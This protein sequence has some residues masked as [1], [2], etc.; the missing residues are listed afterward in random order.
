LKGISP[1]VTFPKRCPG[2]P[3]L[4]IYTIIRLGVACSSPFASGT[5]LVLLIRDFMS[6]TDYFYSVTTAK[7]MF[8]GH[9]SNS[10]S[11]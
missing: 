11:W 6:S 5:L 1:L 8:P 2:K 4:H 9:M 3:L 7:Y 10:M